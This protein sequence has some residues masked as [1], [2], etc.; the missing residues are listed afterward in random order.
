MKPA[1]HHAR[2]L[3][4][5]RMTTPESDVGKANRYRS[6]S[7]LIKTNGGNTQRQVEFVRGVALAFGARCQ[8]AA[9][10]GSSRE[11]PPAGNRGGTHGVSVSRGI[12]SLHPTTRR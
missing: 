9:R 12:E 1:S 8:T 3:K 11:A 5:R 10:Y 4:W 2:G 6:P 7:E